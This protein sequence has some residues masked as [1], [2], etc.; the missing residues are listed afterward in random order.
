MTGFEKNKATKG[1]G[2]VAKGVTCCL[3]REHGADV[4]W[5]K[6]AL[7]PLV[8]GGDLEILGRCVRAQCVWGSEA[9]AQQDSSERETEDL[10]KATLIRPSRK[11]KS[12]TWVIV[13]SVDGVD[14]GILDHLSTKT[15]FLSQA[16][17]GCCSL[18][19][20]FSLP[21]PKKPGLQLG[22]VLSSILTLPIK[23][24]PITHPLTTVL[25]RT[26]SWTDPITNLTSNLSCFW[27]L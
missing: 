5:R 23:W 25:L 27:P 17:C 22:R 15:M 7:S 4:A 1:K 13:P 21:H 16:H 14:E 2:S 9:P 11:M 20:A 19:K 26:S 12:S 10:C 24:T 8:F 3:E 18:N 6:K